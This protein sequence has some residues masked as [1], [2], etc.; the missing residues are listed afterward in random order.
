MRCSAPYVLHFLL[1]L[2]AL[3]TSSAGAQESHYTETDLL[4]AV[5]HFFVNSPCCQSFQK[6]ACG[7]NLHIADVVSLR[8]CEISLGV[9]N[10][11]TVADCNTFALC[12]RYDLNHTS[13]V[14]HAT[15][16]LL[17]QRCY[18]QM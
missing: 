5:S 6:H 12:L 4:T 17:V 1:A 2:A 13:E 18:A 14:E 3:W 8:S 7:W 10:S 15:Q 16:Q 11:A 9:T